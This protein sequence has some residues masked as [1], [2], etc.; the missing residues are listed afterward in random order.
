[1]ASITNLHWSKHLR[2]IAAA[3]MAS[4]TT[5]HGSTH[6][7]QT[8]PKCAVAAIGGGDLC[9]LRYS[10]GL[11][12]RADVTLQG[13]TKSSADVSGCG[14]GGPAQQAGRDEPPHHCAARGDPDASRTGTIQ[15]LADGR[16]SSIQ[17][18]TFLSR[19]LKCLSRVS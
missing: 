18:S 16:H 15:V 11:T 9:S 17:D 7:S 2:S 8:G 5:V 14:D 3:D 10:L 6:K 1:M 12:S 19:F 4:I 13:I